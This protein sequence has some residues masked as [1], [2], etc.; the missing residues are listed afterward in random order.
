[1]MKTRV[2]LL[3]GVTL[4]V[5]SLPTMA[6]AAPSSPQPVAGNPFIG[7]VVDSLA[8]LNT[9]TSFSVFGSGGPSVGTSLLVGPRLVL[10]QRT[11]ITNIGAYV[12]NC[13]A[14]VGGQPLCPDRKPFVV[15]IRPALDGVP[16][17]EVVLA[18]FELSDEPRG[19]LVFVLDL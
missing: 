11:L 16:D 17:P 18:T 8:G 2:S 19:S 15:Q 9:A 12:N 4:A 3:T 5:L 6:A 13:S 7:P 1:M 14:I 10:S